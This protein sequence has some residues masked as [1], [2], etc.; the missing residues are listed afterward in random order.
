MNQRHFDSV[1]RT[2]P[3]LV[4]RRC[5]LG[6]SCVI[7]AAVFAILCVNAFSQSAPK[8]LP[9]QGR[10]TDQNGV[11]VSN[12][13]RLV[14]FKIYDVPTGGSPVWAGE[15]HKTTVNGGLV[16]VLLGSKTPFTGVDFDKTVYLEITVDIN[17]DSAITVADPPMLP[18]QVILPAVFAK[19]SADS[20]LLAGSNWRPLFGTNSTDGAILSTKIASNSISGAQIISNSITAAQILPGTITANQIATGT[21]SLSNLAALVLEA[22]NPPGSITAFGGVNIPDGWL[23]C[24]GQA[25]SASSYPRLYSAIGT[26]WGA[27]YTNIAG[28]QVKLPGT[29]FNLPDLRG[30]FLRGVNGDK[31]DAFQDPDANSRTNFLAGNQGNAVGSLEN[32]GLFAHF[33]H[34]FSEAKGYGGFDSGSDTYIARWADQ[35]ATLGYM[36]TRPES[37]PGPAPMTGRSSVVGGSETRPKNAYVNYIIKY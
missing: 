30:V 34:L 29:D 4:G 5:P 6:L 32:E 16:N 24:D 18:R 33:H 28:V 21:I 1:P 11:G 19:E 8:L 13:V 14:Q 31:A 9:F 36:M 37:L 23:L 12:G 7:V 15:V 20:R 2:S 26:A 35:N 22:L 27:G 17:G 25:F 3:F 10:L